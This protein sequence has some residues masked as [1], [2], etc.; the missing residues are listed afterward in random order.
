MNTQIAGSA[1]KAQGVIFAILGLAFGGGMSV[2][3]VKGGVGGKLFLVVLLVGLF[4]WLAAS[5]IL[6]RLEWTDASMTTVRMGLSRKTIRLDQLAAAKTVRKRN[7]IYYVFSD[8]AGSAIQ[9]PPSLY[10]RRSVWA[11]MLV[12]AIRGCD[13]EADPAVM[14]FLG[15]N[16]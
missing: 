13:A 15:S 1:A 2:A 9:I 12:A 3:H 4:G 8:Q 11:P 6:A 14:A 10:Q 7:A 5:L 16:S